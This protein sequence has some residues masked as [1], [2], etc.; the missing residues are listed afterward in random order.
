MQDFSTGEPLFADAKRLAVGQEIS[1]TRI[2]LGLGLEIAKIDGLQGF[3]HMDRARHAIESGPPPVV[4]PVGSIRV[5][6]DF[7]DKIS[8]SYG[9]KPSALHKQGIS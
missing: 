4:N 8:P 3:V 2:P 1:A 9:V 7:Q 6:L 5:L